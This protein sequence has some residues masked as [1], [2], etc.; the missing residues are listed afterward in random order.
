MLK[1]ADWFDYIHVNGVYFVRI[2]NTSGAIQIQ[3]IIINN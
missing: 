1:S 2:L 3:K